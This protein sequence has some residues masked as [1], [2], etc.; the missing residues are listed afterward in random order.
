MR[1]KKRIRYCF[2]IV[3]FFTLL[4]YYKYQSKKLGDWPVVNKISTQSITDSVIH[5]ST[6]VKDSVQ[7][8]AATV[9][10][11]TKAITVRDEKD[12]SIPLLQYIS[13]VSFATGDSTAQLRMCLQMYFCAE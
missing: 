2:G 6:I 1:R 10:R 13:N 3:I 9:N 11:T 12:L 7:P 5:R 8:T 4:G